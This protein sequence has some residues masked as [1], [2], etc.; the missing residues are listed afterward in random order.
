MV[1]T[2]LG[3]TALVLLSLFFVR[4]GNKEGESPFA[5]TLRRW[6]LRQADGER[7]RVPRRVWRNPIAW[8]EAATRASAGGRSWI[9]WIFS[10]AGLAAG[11]LL[12]L[13]FE[14]QWWGLTAA[15]PARFDIGR[16]W[17]VKLVWIQLAVILLI[18]TNTAA[19]TLTREKESQT[20]ELL[21]STPLTSAYIARG[22]VEGL[23]R[24]V[25]PLIAAPALTLLFFVI[26][27]L[28]RGGQAIAT[29]ES[30]IMVPVLLVAFA[31]TAAMVGLQ[32]SLLSKKTVQAVML[33][34]GSVLGATA[35]LWGCGHA[36][37]TASPPI[38]SVLLPFLPLS[39]VAS[40]IDVNVIAASAPTPPS[41]PQ[42]AAYRI[43]RG[44]ASLAAAGLYFAVTFA[45]YRNLVRSFD[46]T[47]RKQSA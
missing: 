17:L 46:M 12:L 29:L 20:M 22:M 19:S 35:A 38:A 18:V 30:V 14:S 31:S 23:V 34:T 4:R 36:I 43:T 16:D 11:L 15:N 39:S 47:V 26:A 40:L 42:L 5:A 44:I 37:A 25:L 32:F 24:F 8:R 10:A 3:S 13:A 7:R 28:A 27:D 45:M 41:A 21:L 33:S 6:V 1:L 9:R 2:T